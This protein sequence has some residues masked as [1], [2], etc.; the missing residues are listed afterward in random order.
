MFAFL[1]TLLFKRF[2]SRPFLSYYWHS[3]L[4]SLDNLSTKA[5]S[6][7]SSNRNNFSKKDF[8]SSILCHW[9]KPALKLAGSASPEPCTVNSDLSPTPLG[10]GQG[11]GKGL[12]TCVYTAAS[13]PM[14][15]LGIWGER[16]RLDTPN[17]DGLLPAK[18]WKFVWKLNRLF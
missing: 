1:S 12:P 4:I 9:E 5:A 18:A 13:P 2:F 8:R 14:T 15:G 17:W 3:F 6:L 16:Q 11:L 10:I 7:A